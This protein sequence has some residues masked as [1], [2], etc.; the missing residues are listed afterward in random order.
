MRTIARRIN[1]QRIKAEYIAGNISQR[2]L[3]MK[4]H[5]PVSTLQARAHRGR[6]N[7]ERQAASAIVTQKA[8]EKT[9]K[10]VENN[11]VLAAEIKRKGLEL[12]NRLLDEFSEMTGTEHREY[13]GRNLTDIRRLRDITAAYKDLTD[14]L[15][16]EEDN[17]ALEKLDELLEVAWNAA[18]E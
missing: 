9:A 7:E 14:D 15:P 10:S 8:I 1:W 11:A 3:A 18:H 13:K 12:V 5:V 16:K 2:K 17:S 6:W 4:H